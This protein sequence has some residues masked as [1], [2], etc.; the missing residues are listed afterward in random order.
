MPHLA[1]LA[2]I[3]ALGV[4]LG[5]EELARHSLNNVVFQCPFDRHHLLTSLDYCLKESVSEC[6]LQPR[7]GIPLFVDWYRVDYF[8][9]PPA[10]RRDLFILVFEW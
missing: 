2:A 6:W 7:S 4:N 3:L 8:D 9:I 10:Q 5:D 1:R